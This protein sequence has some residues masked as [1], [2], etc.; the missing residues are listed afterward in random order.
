MS[1]WSFGIITVENPPY[2]KEVI[3]SIRHQEIPHYEVIIVGGKE[4]FGADIWLPFDESLKKGFI[5]KK[6]NLIAQIAKF[7]NLCI[8]HDYVSLDSTWYNGFQYY[9]YN[10]LTCTNK[11]FNNDYTRF[12]D[13][14]VIGNDSWHDFDDNCK[15]PFNENGRLLNY[16]LKLNN[17]YARWFY[18]SGAYF[19][20]KKEI[21]LNTPFDESRIWG[22]GE[23]VKFCRELYF[24]YGSSV[25]N[26][27]PFSSVYFLKQK[28]RAPWECLPEIN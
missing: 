23:D 7:E 14:A 17:I 5:T 20:T 13:W 22:Q 8:L 10:W 12:R 9:G 16:K 27:N 1:Q 19:C 11:I 26:F 28:E 15:P 2:L 25:F 6:K 4:N 24:K 3:S 21:L 18:Y